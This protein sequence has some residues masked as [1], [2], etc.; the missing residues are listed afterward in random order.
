[1]HQG[2]GHQ[3]SVER[4]PMRTRQTPPSQAFSSLSGSGSKTLSGTVIFPFNTS[5]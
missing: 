3:H 1:M 5:G 4:I 2:L